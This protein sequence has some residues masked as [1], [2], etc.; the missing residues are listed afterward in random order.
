M[1]FTLSVYVGSNHFPDVCNSKVEK[2]QLKIQQIC[3]QTRYLL[4]I[5]GFSLAID[6]IFECGMV[7]TA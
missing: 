7:V 2:I 4:E 6:Y 1:H 3:I 5:V